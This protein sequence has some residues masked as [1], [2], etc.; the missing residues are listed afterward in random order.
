MLVF[1]FRFG[2]FVNVGLAGWYCHRCCGFWIVLGWCVLLGVL[3]CNFSLWWLGLLVAG[4]VGLV[5]GL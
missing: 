5:C 1:W 2:M 4:L 3:I